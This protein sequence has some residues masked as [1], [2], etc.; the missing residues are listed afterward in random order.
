MCG[1]GGILRF[2]D[3]PIDQDRLLRMQAALAIRGPDDRGLF[4]DGRL[5]FVHTR[6]AILDV[7][8]G[9]QPMSL[10]GPGQNLTV[11]FNGEIYNHRELRR[12]LESKGHRFTTDHSDTEVLLHGY[13]EWSED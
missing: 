7:P 11:V 10:R 8:G 2:D 9:K 3:Q 13:R 12:E 1:I 6:L 5:G 4:I